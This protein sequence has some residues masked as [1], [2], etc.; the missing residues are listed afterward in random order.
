MLG[1]GK[2]SVTEYLIVPS[3]LGCSPSG[4]ISSGR[5]GD[6]PNLAERTGRGAMW[7]LRLRLVVKGRGGA[8][9]GADRGSRSARYQVAVAREGD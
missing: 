8:E 4:L 6:W 9:E 3:A 1:E 2:L 5:G 7:N